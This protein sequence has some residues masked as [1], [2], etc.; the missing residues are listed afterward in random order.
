M[1]YATCTLAQF[2]KID[3]LLSACLCRPPIEDVMAH[4]LAS[5]EYANEVYFRPEWELYDACADVMG[6]TA[7][8]A[9]PSAIEAAADFVT[10]A[11]SS[12][13]MV[14]DED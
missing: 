3:A 1:T 12:S 11:L 7:V 9:F 8:Q 5:R 6:L 2:E 4:P 10:R 13:S 14:V